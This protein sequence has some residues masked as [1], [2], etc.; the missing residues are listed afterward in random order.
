MKR[1][2]HFQE[3]EILIIIEFICFIYNEIIIQFI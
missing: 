3:R 2:D 1:K